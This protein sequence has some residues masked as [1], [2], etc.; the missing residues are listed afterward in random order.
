MKNTI[1]VV[2][3]AIILGVSSLW[4]EDVVLN[5]VQPTDLSAVEKYFS[6][7]SGGNDNIDPDGL[8]EITRDT[9][10][11]MFM[12]KDGHSV[13]Y[14]TYVRMIE[15][16]DKMTANMPDYQ[17]EMYRTSILK[18]IERAIKM[19]NLTADEGTELK[20]KLGISTDYTPQSIAY[21]TFVRMIENFNKLPDSLPA[22][23]KETVRQSIVQSIERAVQLGNLT[24]A[25]ADSLKKTLGAGDGY[26]AHSQMYPTFL[27]MVENFNKL[28]DNLPAS[29]KE[30]IKQTILKKIETAL[31]SKQLKPEEAAELKKKLGV[32]VT[33]VPDDNPAPTPADNTPSNDPNNTP[34]PAPDNNTP[35]ND[36]NNI[37]APAT[38]SNTEPAN[39]PTPSPAPS[40]SQD[41]NWLP[42][43]VMPVTPAEPVP[44]NDNSEENWLPCP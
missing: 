40:D 41:D 10:G 27:R 19:G 4:A 11:R 23:Y 7:D 1:L 36:P 29:Y 34:A 25:E 17:K 44:S 16:F 39:N 42:C 24:Q 28:P 12:V 37:P 38:P 8:P 15:K 2:F 22:S 31:S 32:D 26:V 13:A 5:A 6:K 20:G 3:S 21:P 9:Q 33:P 18:S 35:S 43:P 30:G 14:G